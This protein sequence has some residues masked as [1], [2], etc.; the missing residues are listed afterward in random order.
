MIR[1]EIEISKQKNVA[2]SLIHHT[3]MF[4]KNSIIN[5]LPQNIPLGPSAF[6]SQH[7]VC[8]WPILTVRL[9]WEHGERP[10]EAHSPPHTASRLPPSCWILMTLNKIC[11]VEEGWADT[12]EGNVQQC[13]ASPLGLLGLTC[14]NSPEGIAEPFEVAEMLPWCHFSEF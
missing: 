6:C 10:C 12:S 2:I 5:W 8:L 4:K 1:P 13:G 9:L 3:S 7:T 11:R 14:Q